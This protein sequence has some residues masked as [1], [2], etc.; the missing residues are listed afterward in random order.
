MTDESISAPTDSPPPRI[1][2]LLLCMAVAATLLTVLQNRGPPAAF[3]RITAG[4]FVGMAESSTFLAVGS[5][6]CAMS[7]YWRAKGFA[8]LLQ[9]GQWVLLGYSIPIIRLVYEVLFS[10]AFADRALSSRN[11]LLWHF[12]DFALLGYYLGLA[13]LSSG[14]P[15]L[16]LYAWGAWR[17]ADTRPWRTLFIWVAIRSAWRSTQFVNPLLG[18]S[19]L[20][21][22]ENINSACFATMSISLAVNSLLAAWAIANDIKGRRPR[23]WTHW[24]RAALM[25]TGNL[26]SL[27]RSLLA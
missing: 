12:A 21:W 8:T 4:Q 27:G 10:A 2:H 18:G 22:L 13:I 24:A 17:V 11:I 15:L 16:L 19:T 3:Q 26:L 5:T 14:L 20:R 7:L 9:P 1:H 23:Y 25:T 6:L